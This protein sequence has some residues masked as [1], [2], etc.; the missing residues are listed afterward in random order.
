MDGE[1]VETI[2]EIICFLFHYFLWWVSKMYF[3]DH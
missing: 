2:C 1:V 3:W